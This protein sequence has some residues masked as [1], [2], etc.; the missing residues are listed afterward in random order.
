MRVDFVTEHKFRLD[1]HGIPTQALL[2]LPKGTK[3]F[4][5]RL[6]WSLSALSQRSG[7]NLVGSGK[8]SLFWWRTQEDKPTTDC[9]PLVGFQNSGIG[10][11]TPAGIS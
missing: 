6:S 8:Q 11:I 1:T 4:S 7:S 2:P 3:A 10:F 5:M 9:F